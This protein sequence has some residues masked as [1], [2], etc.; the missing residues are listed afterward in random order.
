MNS[1][2]KQ[3]II[4]GIVCSILVI[5]ALHFLVFRANANEYKN[6][7]DNYR[8]VQAQYES[9]QLPKGQQEI[10]A[11]DLETVDYSINFWEIFD[12]ADMEVPTEL[13]GGATN[14]EE[15]NIIFKE[16]FL[17]L[18]NK[19]ITEWL[20]RP[21][22]EQLAELTF[23]TEN[24]GWFFLNELP[25]SASNSNVAVSDLLRDLK[26][27]DSIIKETTE[28]SNLWYQKEPQYRQELQIFGLDLNRREQMRS[29]FGDTVAMLYTLNRLDLVR[30]AV[31]K[32]EVGIFDDKDYDFF[33][34]DLFRYEKYELVDRNV[35][36]AL[37]TLDNVITI[38]DKHGIE[39]IRE[40]KILEARKINWPPKEDTETEEEAEDATTAT[41]MGMDE[42]MMME[43]MMM[44]GGRGEGMDPSMMMGKGGMMGGAAPVEEEDNSIGAA[45]PL[46]VSMVGTNSEIMNVLYEISNV[47]R[48]YQVDKFRFQ[49]LPQDD[50]KV[51]A[52]FV[53]QTLS[54]YNEY[55]QAAEV[56]EIIDRLIRN[57]NW[58]ATEGGVNVDDNY[59]PDPE[60]AEQPNY[61][62]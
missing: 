27:T 21:E 12:K 57:K 47:A 30:E 18:Y 24:S 45:V 50:N 32:E 43:M 1:K 38:A 46:E 56:Q 25:E 41:G 39:E 22:S 14:E 59:I 48:H 34:L 7:R 55:K 2:K 16:N 53:I 17:M 44:G 37:D 49:A 62:L 33:L 23:L 29:Y 8:A 51:Q 54:Y 58:L 60:N 26:D 28:G 11:F 19:Y 5:G 42:M 20:D 3:Q 40:V 36:T 10:Y 6:K 35:F 61:S 4:I 52:T 31:E 15:A 9:Q 13:K